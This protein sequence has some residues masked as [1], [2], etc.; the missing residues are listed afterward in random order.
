MTR[1]LTVV[2][3]VT[4][5]L[6]A[7]FNQYFLT[8]SGAATAFSGVASVYSTGAFPLNPALG[9]IQSGFAA[10]LYYTNLFS[11]QELQLGGVLASFS[12]RSHRVGIH[13]S[14]FGYA[15]YR[16]TMVQLNYARQWFEG[17]L[18]VGAAAQLYYLTIRN[19]GNR[20]AFGVNMGFLYRFNSTV[21]VG[22]VIMNANEP[23]L[24]GIT[25]Q[26]P[27]LMAFGVSIHPVE[28]GEI[29]AAVSKE[30]DYPVEYRIGFF[31]R[32]N[33]QLAVYS[34]YSTSGPQPAGGIRL[35]VRHWSVH[36]VVQ[37]HFLLGATQLVGI[38]FNGGKHP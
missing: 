7:A 11:L 2:L 37:Y 8:P 24:S 38:T 33:N 28:R 18:T 34:G 10:Q 6:P 17:R 14:S 22:G 16:E 5:P 26:L 29:V 9:A 23:R 19:Y 30:S 20:A 21:S 13:L 36:Y 12:I 32:I 15:L 31:Y 1:I 3:L 4:L 25:E 27:Y 35:Q